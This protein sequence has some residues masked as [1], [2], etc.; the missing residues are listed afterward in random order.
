[1]KKVGQATTGAERELE[2]AIGRIADWAGCDIAYAPVDGG[3][4]NANF[5]VSV[6]GKEHDFFV[7]MPGKGTEMFVDR[8]AA[9]DAS[10][11]AAKSG[12]GAEVCHFLE[13]EGV[14]IFKF[15]EGFRTS[16][17]GDYLI[18][19]VR[20]NAVRALRG[21]SQQEPLDLTKTIFDQ[22]DEHQAQIA[23]LGGYTPLDKTWADKQYRLARE[24]LEASGIDLVPCMNDTLAGNFML[25][26]RYEITLVD[27]EY[28]SNNDPHYELALW[29]CEMVFPPE[30]E[31][32]MI[33]EYF[34]RADEQA[35]ARVN[36]YKALADIKWSN[37][38][39]VQRQ[40]SHLDFD[41]HKYGAWKHMRA[42]VFMHD[43]QWEADLRRV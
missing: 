35:V 1:M 8:R 16:T 33:E 13:E 19:E 30:I 28:A 31:R 12:Y 10:K 15:V 43:P 7:K 42:R 23:E 5:R 40:V 41:F 6:S 3:I 21:F 18:P 37:W 26:D 17:N 25:N 4:S 2:A 36:V 9:H 22:I 20:T 32:E 11:A 14:E 38:A 29:F 24:A 39:W 34:G 27:F